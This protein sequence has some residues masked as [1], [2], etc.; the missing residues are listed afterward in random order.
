[1][2]GLVGLGQAPCCHFPHAHIPLTGINGACM[3]P[4]PEH[5]G[6]AQS[7]QE[8]GLGGKVGAVTLVGT[9]HCTERGHS[10][11][12][13]RMGQLDRAPMHLGSLEFQGTTEHSHQ[14]HSHLKSCS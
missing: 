3:R 8:P 12:C 4:T 13:R 2:R 11:S 5:M 7:S 10:L 9:L 14:A 6:T 1:M